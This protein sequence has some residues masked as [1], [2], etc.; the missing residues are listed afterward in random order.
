MTATALVFTAA[1]I[2]LLAGIAW[3][4]AR[5]FEIHPLAAAA[6]AA[7]GLAWHALG[8]LGRGWV[9]A[10]WW[11]PLLGMAL[12]V[13]AA[14]IPIAL[15]AAMKRRWP[16][17]PGDGILMGGIGAVLGPVGLAWS[18]L[19]AAP[20]AAAH[21]ACLQ[22]KRRRAFQ[23]GYVP[24]GPGMAGGAAL[25][26]LAFLAGAPLAQENEVLAPAERDAMGA[27]VLA[28]VVAPGPPGAAQ[29]PVA[30]AVAEPLALPELAA[31][32][33]L[34][35]GRGVEIE[36][37]PARSL[38]PVDSLEAPPPAPFEYGGTLAGLLDLVA[39]RYRY[40]WEWRG[41]H[42]V[43]FR[44]WDAEFA[45]A[46]RPLPLSLGAAVWEI[47][48]DRHQT[49]R[50]VLESWANEAGW[51]LTWSADRDYALGADARFP[52]TFLAAVDG[53]LA[54]PATSGTLVATAYRTNRHLVIAEV[55]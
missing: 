46:T 40:R 22:R 39:A 33:A 12:G 4:D 48:L 15:A 28:P 29:S 54:D 32:I 7:T 42:V 35:T 25:V 55:P 44:Y 34:L 20:L 16:I 30:I 45:A 9:A 13:A 37:R 53:V 51:S 49:L 31:R 41:R 10:A 21:R 50:A 5:R 14:A 6:L 11:M 23:R 47:D 1:V 3:T 27:V 24:F 19:A 17:M 18:L 8:G 38:D 36:E 43:F 52:G 2:G 26:L